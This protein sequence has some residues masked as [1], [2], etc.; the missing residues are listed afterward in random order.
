VALSADV[1]LLGLDG[2]MMPVPALMTRRTGNL[3]ADIA[4]HGGENCSGA[5][6]ECSRTSDRRINSGFE[7][8]IVVNGRHASTSSLWRW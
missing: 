7:I 8:E 1:T 3:D 5:V 4:A 2:G 6:H